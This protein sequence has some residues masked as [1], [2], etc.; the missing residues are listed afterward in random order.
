MNALESAIMTKYNS[1]PHNTL[2]NSL[3]GFYN[4]LAPDNAEFPYGVFKIIG[5]I[6]EATFGVTVPRQIEKIVVRIWIYDNTYGDKTN[7][8]NYEQYVHDL[9]DYA[10]LSVASYSFMT[11]T[12]MDS[13]I[14]LDDDVWQNANTYRIE[15]E[16]N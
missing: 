10:T 13:K 8:N 7:I 1:L 2:Y 11:M 9:F 4:T 14:D 16:E 3:N 15:I 5:R 6:P 12:R